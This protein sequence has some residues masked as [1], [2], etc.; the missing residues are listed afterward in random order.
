M[1][2]ERRLTEFDRTVL[3]KITGLTDCYLGTSKFPVC[4]LN[5]LKKADKHFLHFHDAFHGL[6]AHIQ[7]DFHLE[8]Y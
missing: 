7:F 2:M 3:H 6:Q 8:K 1:L 5:V 4:S